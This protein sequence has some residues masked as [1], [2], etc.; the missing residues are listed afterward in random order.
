MARQLTFAHRVTQCPLDHVEPLRAALQDAC[1]MAL[2]LVDIFAFAR[3]D[4]EHA[5]AL[6]IADRLAQDIHA[7]IAQ[8]RERI[9]G[10]LVR[11]L[12]DHL[13]H[14]QRDAIQHR[15]E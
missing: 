9:G 8:A 12:A 15:A 4:L 3:N 6:H 10:R 13:L 7:A 1:R 14:R 5:P 11:R 2:E